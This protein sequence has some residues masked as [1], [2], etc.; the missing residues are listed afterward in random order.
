[1]TFLHILWPLFCVV[2][3]IYG[4]YSIYYGIK[5][6]L[7]ERRILRNYW[8]RTYYTDL[9]AVRQGWLYITIGIVSLG[10]ILFGLLS[11]GI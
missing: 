3:T 9:S 8:N 1:L 11:F 2:V 10:I 4:I 7:R 5:Y 6:G